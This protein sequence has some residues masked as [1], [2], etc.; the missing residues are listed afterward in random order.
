[1]KKSYLLALLTQFII[2]S[3]IAQN[4][5][6]LWENFEAET[7]DY[8]LVEYPEGDPPNLYPNWLNFDIDGIVDG[9]GSATARPDEWFLSFGFADVD[10]SNTVLASNSWLQ[11]ESDFADNW[12]ITPRIHIQ[13]DLANL[14]WKSAPFQLPRYMDGYQVLVST[15]NNLETSFTD[16]LAVFAEF[17]GTLTTDIEDT[18]TYVFTQG[19]MHT[20]LEYD[21]VDVT[22]HGGILQQWQASLADYQG[23]N[24]F[25]AFRH[26][27]VD[28]NL[29]SID[30]ILVLGTGS[31]G[32][33]ERSDAFSFR[34]YPNPVAR[35][36]EITL[37]YELLDRASVSYSIL[38]IEGK[39]LLQKNGHTQ[40]A[41]SHKS[42]IN[43][44]SFSAGTYIVSVRL[45][46]RIYSE[47]I[48][49]MD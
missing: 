33:E 42:Q 30:D 13:D 22:R 37:E 43:V 9:S 27:S 35:T 47:R 44:A 10:S 7:I 23:E 15:T 5:T 25:I 18:A 39:V 28:D 24:I 8:I 40:L 3:A 16:T 21:S 14:Y 34:M 31:V 20:E 17:N 49:L 48:T 12:L 41:G 6:L 26:N 45:N 46:D 29:I 1:M 32:I 19:I 36:G 4:D 38:S 2:N 11:N